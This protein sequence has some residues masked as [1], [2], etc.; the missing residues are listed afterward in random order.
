[1]PNDINL[2]ELVINK[3]TKEQYTT[4]KEAGAIS[5]T[6]LYL[7]SDSSE[8]TS[9]VEAKDVYVS[10]ETSAA[11]NI[12]AGA[13]VNQALEKLNEDIELQATTKAPMYTYGTEDLVAGESEL[14]EGI[15]YF[16]YE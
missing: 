11:L 10:S 3:L 1:M 15:L 2:N 14:A 13:N 6:E 5:N 12:E 4:M 16:V 8:S 7:V 9:L